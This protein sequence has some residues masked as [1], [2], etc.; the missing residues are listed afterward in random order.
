MAVRDVFSL[1]LESYKS[2]QEKHF[3]CHEGKWYTAE[4]EDPMQ[5]DEKYCTLLASEKSVCFSSVEH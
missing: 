3:E 2:F 5:I 4:G 1:T